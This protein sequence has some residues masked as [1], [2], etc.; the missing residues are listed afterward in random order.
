M[1]WGV[2]EQGG[3]GDSDGDIRADEDK[4]L[5]KETIGER[6]GDGDLES[7]STRKLRQKHAD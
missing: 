7:M 5:D 6:W 4:W 3:W 2:R 1:G